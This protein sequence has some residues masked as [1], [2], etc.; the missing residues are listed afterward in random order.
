[1]VDLVSEHRVIATDLVSA[2]G[3]QLLDLWRV[4]KYNQGVSV[5]KIQCA[6]GHIWDADLSQLKS[7]CWCPDCKALK[8]RTPNDEVKALVESKNGTLIEDAMINGRRFLTIQCNQDN[9]IW[10]AA[11][12]AIKKGTWCRE[13]FKRNKVKQIEPNTAISFLSE[14][15]WELLTTTQFALWSDIDVRCIKHNLQWTT[16]FGLLSKGKSKCKLCAWD[17]ASYE[18]ISNKAGE[19]GYEIKKWMIKGL[20]QL[21]VELYC[22]KHDY[23]WRTASNYI[24]KDDRICYHCARNER[25]T[26]YETIKALVESRDGILLTENCLGSTTRILVR[27]NKDQHEWETT[28]D[29][30]NSGGHWC[31]KCPW[32]K[33]GLVFDFLKE[34]LPDQE[35]VWNSRPFEWLKSY[36]LLE[37]DI[38]IPGLKLAIEYD[39]Q[40]HFGPVRYAEEQTMEDAIK[41]YEDLKLRDQLK[42]TLIAQHPEDVHHFLRIKYDEPITKEHLAARLK[43]IGIC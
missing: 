30:L 16:T 38:W 22:P 27:C 31:P 29:S 33:Q 35:M 15:G 3:G 14:R 36:K 26:S 24:L 2:K 37:I 40:Q 34:L 5:C 32:V 7:G 12:G 19:R 1:M 39:G 11:L 25:K 17:V 6:L 21:R 9:N 41:A 10:T 43:E 23:T 8:R 20:S 28:Y 18:T 4:K 13:C 42:D